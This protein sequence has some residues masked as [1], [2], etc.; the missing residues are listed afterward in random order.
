MNL[1]RGVLKAQGLNVRQFDSKKELDALSQ[2]T[3]SGYVILSAFSE[4]GVDEGALLF[5]TGQGVGS[6]F[7][8]HGISKVVYGD[9]SV[10]HFFNALAAQFGAVD[11]VELSL[12]QVDLVLA[13]N[14]KLKLER[15]IPKGGVKS[16]VRS[17]YDS[18]LIQSISDQ[19]PEESQSKESLFKK[20]GLAGIGR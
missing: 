3:F 16:L 17:N 15:P 20:F 11:V 13:F 14:A 19:K 6:V 10:S 1:P 4:W 8:Y 2:D 9:A 12:Q 7:E 18:K 5:R